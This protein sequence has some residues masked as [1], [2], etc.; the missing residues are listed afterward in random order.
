MSIEVQDGWDVANL[1]IH[2]AFDELQEASRAARVGAVDVPAIG[3]IECFYLA[4]E[5][6]QRQATARRHL[7]K[8]VALF[9]AG[10][11]SLIHH[12]SA[13]YPE[14]KSGGRFVQK[15]EGAF[16]AKRIEPG[17]G[18]YKTFYERVRH[19]IVHPDS[20][21]KIATVNQLGFL[22]VHAGIRSGWD[23][24]KRL[25]DAVGEPHDADSWSVMCNAHGVPANPSGTDFPDLRGLKVALYKRHLDELNSTGAA[26]GEDP[27][28]A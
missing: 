10:M 13:K 1:V 11:E 9:Q 25:G 23:A 2:G 21:R 3:P 26:G 5:M 4:G 16:R 20:A 17:L 8:T 24:F 7:V 27:I 19:A 18:D 12:W 22:S 6:T 28:S 15:W 14:I